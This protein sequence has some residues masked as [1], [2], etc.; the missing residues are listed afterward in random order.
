VKNDRGN[1]AVTRPGIDLEYVG[2]VEREKYIDSYWCSYNSEYY[3]RATL[4][5]AIATL[6]VANL[7]IGITESILIIV[8][9]P[10][11]MK[12]TITIR[13]DD[14]NARNVTWIEAKDQ[15]RVSIYAAYGWITTWSSITSTIGNSCTVLVYYV[16]DG[17]TVSALATDINLHLTRTHSSIPNTLVTKLEALHYRC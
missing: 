6:A 17:L 13:F 14:L 1:G 15:V 11:L 12:I 2:L 3:C 9:S 5:V 7:V 10:Y 16:L 4:R 8:R